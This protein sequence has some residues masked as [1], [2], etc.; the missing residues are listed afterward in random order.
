M[1]Q[2]TLSDKEYTCQLSRILRETHAWGLETS[3][4]RIK[5]NFS[6]LT[7]KSGPVVLKKLRFISDLLCII[8][9]L[10]ITIAKAFKCLQSV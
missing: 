10:F 4:S 3:I 9:L 1:Q 7:D 2:D 6:G 8:S 5:D